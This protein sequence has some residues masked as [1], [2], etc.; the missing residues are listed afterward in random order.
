MGIAVGRGG[1]DAEVEEL[2]SERSA[3]KFS[4]NNEFRSVMIY[5]GVSMY[6]MKRG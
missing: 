1:E 5:F 2:T 4:F 3:M 6:H